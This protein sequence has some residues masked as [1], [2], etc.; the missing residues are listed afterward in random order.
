MIFSYMP[1][2]FRT[3]KN[4]RLG[5]PANGLDMNKISIAGFGNVISATT[6]VGPQKNWAVTSILRMLEMC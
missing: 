5:Q 3:A 2:R 1:V 6:N 4:P